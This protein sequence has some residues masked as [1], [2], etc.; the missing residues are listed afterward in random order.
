[1]GITAGELLTA[2][3]DNERVTPTQL[4]REIDWGV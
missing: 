2:I 1:M 3:A 4:Q